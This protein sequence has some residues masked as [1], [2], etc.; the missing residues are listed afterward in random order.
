[1]TSVQAVTDQNKPLSWGTRVCYG[2]GDTAQNV[3]WGAMGILTF[4]YT[5]YAGVDPA[6]VGLVMLISR[7]FDGFSDVIMGFIVE[8]TNSK[9]GK[10]RPWILWMSL[11][12]ALSIVLIYTVPQT[13][14]LLQFAYIFVTYNFCTTICYTALNLPYGSLSAMMTRVSKERD[15][16]SITRMCL[17]PWGRILS[18]AATLPLIKVFGDTQAAWVEVMAMWAVLALALL[19]LCFKQCKETVVIEA[20]QKVD[21]IPV[22]KAL[23]ALVLNK[24]F[25]SAAMIWTM[26]NVIFTVTGTV[27]PYYC[28]YIFMNDSLYSILYLVETLVTIGVMIAF[29]PKLLKRFGKRN[30]SLA[31]VIIC[32]IGHII[33]LFDPLNFNMLVFSCVIRGIGFA[34]I[35]SVIF[36]FLGDVVEY[37]QWKFHIRQEGLIF[38]GGSVGTKV[39]SGLTSAIVTGL[40]SLTGYVASSSG[41]VSQSQEAINMVVS[42]YKYAPILVWVILIF[43][44]VTY[45]LDKIYP[46]I[47]KDLVEREAKGEL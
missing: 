35:Q 16:L 3:V 4:F 6:I 29:S 38:S 19:L 10:S 31:G 30:M 28:K 45:K 12:F 5:D 39:G 47:M 18:V 25:W 20:R 37:G 26:Q 22:G 13:T 46:Q 42:I 11:P 32:L 17:S 41:V 14:P 1:M 33:F 27:L 36:G 15:M 23:K 2:L 34:P 44:L 43:I 21:K 24:Y 7:C 8:K 9:W 40:L